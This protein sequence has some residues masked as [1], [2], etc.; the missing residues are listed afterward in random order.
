MLKMARRAEGIARRGRVRGA[1]RVNL[2]ASGPAR[3]R[4]PFSLSEHPADVLGCE[5]QWAR[6]ERLD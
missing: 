2:P 3:A 5:H 1:V 4:P 6:V